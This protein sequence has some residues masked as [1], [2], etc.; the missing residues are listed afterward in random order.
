[1]KVPFF[2]GMVRDR[3][4]SAKDL[5]G[6][7][8]SRD[9]LRCQRAHHPARGM[10]SDPAGGLPFVHAGHYQV[11]EKMAELYDR[12]QAGERPCHMTVAVSRPI[13]RQQGDILNQQ[14][15]RVSTVVGWLAGKAGA[16][17]AGPLAGTPVG[18]ITGGA[19]SVVA[20]W[21]MLRSI[22]TFHVGDVLVSLSAK[23]HGGIGPQTSSLMFI[24]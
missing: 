10:L 6:N 3:H 20:G 22:P 11:V 8:P 18:A 24:M 4:A 15:Q 12:M 16:S 23:V 17:V 9:H 19:V 13:S 14:R 21:A 2:V 5:S 7:R 1:M